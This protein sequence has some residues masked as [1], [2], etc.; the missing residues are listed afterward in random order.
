MGK[1]RLFFPQ[2][3]LDRWLVNRVA[4]L[5]LDQLRLRDSG[6][7]FRLVEGVR[8]LNEVSGAE[9]P[10]DVCGTVRSVAY[11][12]EL[13]AELLGDSM[14]IAENAYQVVPGW[15]ATPVSGSAELRLGSEP[16]P[17]AA[18]LDHEMSQ[19]MARNA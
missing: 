10:F 18:D 13:G 11:L 16:A 14:I 1:N 15:L 2:A 6:R 19:F 9:D 8:V 17:P 4:D 3:A 5:S 12:L 7:R